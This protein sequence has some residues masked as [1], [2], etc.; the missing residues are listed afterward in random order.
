[1]VTLTNWRERMGE[2]MRLRDFRPR[3]QEGYSLAVRL[4]LDRVQLE[5]ETITEEDL[6]RYFLYLREE[7]KAAP[8]SITIALCALRFF[9]VHTLR[10]DWP[11]FELL[12]VNKPRVLPV[13][14]SR[15]EVR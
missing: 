14:L 4:F 2:D 10:R 13:V 5:P 15:A 12:R 3:T 7:K 9:F 6:R 11:I 8:S 1:M